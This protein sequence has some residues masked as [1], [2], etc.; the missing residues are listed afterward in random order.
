MVDSVVTWLQIKNTVLE[1]ILTN[2]TSDT[3]C[4]A[5]LYG[6]TNAATGT[7]ATGLSQFQR[8]LNV[9]QPGETALPCRQVVPTSL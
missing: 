8:Q 9:L 5:A 1:T 6:N 4:I 7:A 3:G 2:R